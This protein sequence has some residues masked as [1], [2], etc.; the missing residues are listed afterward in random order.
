MS[1]KQYTEEE[2]QRA[3]KAG[4]TLIDIDKVIE[5]K[6][7]ALKKMLP[8]FVTG[9][10][11]RIIRQEF[12]N[13]LLIRHGHLMGTEFIDAVLED[14]NTKLDVVGL[15][16]IPEKDRCI[17]ASNHPLGGLDG[18]ALMLA[19]SKKRSDIVF[20]VNDLLMNVKNLEPLFIPI[21]KLGSNTENIRIINET[22]ASDKLI[23]Y[24]PFG[25]VSRKKGGEIKDLEWK[26]TFI[27]KAKRFK[28]D[29]IPTFITGRNTNHFYNIADWR[30]RLHIKTNFEMMLLPDEMAR[31]KN[32]TIKI[33]FGKNV[34]YR[35]FD[36]RHSSNE[37]AELMRQYVYTLDTENPEPF[38]T[39][40]ENKKP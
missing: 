32:Q 30:K 15:D 38:E 22:F 16:N 19:V 18:M 24:F 33:T 4:I 10:M 27:T 31:Q 20:P 13:T 12:L 8:G 28:R 5:N 26:P 3:L 40:V 17:V 39:W 6:S 37:W 1:D 14:M 9:L 25:L 7:P 21:N 35:F 2:K 11:K 36:K 23:C 29:I 34:S